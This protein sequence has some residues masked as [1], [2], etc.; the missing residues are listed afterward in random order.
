MFGRVPAPGAVRRRVVRPGSRARPHP[1]AARWPPPRPGRACLSTRQF[2]REFHAQTG[3]TPAKA[4]E[5]L[6]AEAARTRLEAGS[7]SIEQVA[8]AVGFGD[9]ERMRR[10]FVRVFGQPPQALRRL[11]RGTVV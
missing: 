3:Q 8:D 9:A 7:E 5:R 11:A 10:A 6:R 1:R 2:A 4:I